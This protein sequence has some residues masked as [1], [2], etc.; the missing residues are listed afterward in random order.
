MNTTNL[1]TMQTYKS[2]TKTATTASQHYSSHQSQGSIL[3]GDR[4][5][6]ARGAG[7]NEISKNFE[8]KSEIFNNLNTV[9]YYDKMGCCF[10]ENNQENQ[11]GLSNGAI[12][13]GDENSRM[14]TTLLQN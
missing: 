5:I 1:S 2:P 11:N 12:N 9:P 14:Y 4:F 7:Q 13:S 6:S 3:V 10:E 8:T